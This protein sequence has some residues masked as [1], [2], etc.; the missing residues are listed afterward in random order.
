GDAGVTVN[1]DNAVEAL[2]S[3]LPTRRIEAWHYTDLRRLLNTVPA[4]DATAKPAALRPLLEGSAILR[5]ANGVA[6]TAAP[7][8]G[9]EVARFQ[10]LLAAGDM[11]AAMAPVDADD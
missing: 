9:V 5:V 8:D 3:G 10:D 7:I 4:F 11:R 1:R 2:K 6:E